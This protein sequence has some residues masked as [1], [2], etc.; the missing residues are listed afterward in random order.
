[1][2]WT[3]QTLKALREGRGWSHE[4]MGDKLGVSMTQI[5]RMEQG[6]RNITP[7]ISRLL[8]YIAG[9]APKRRRE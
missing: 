8:D 6:T 9:R 3:P 4:E 1:M 2:E 5:Y 7:T